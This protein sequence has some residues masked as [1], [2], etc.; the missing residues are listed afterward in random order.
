[1][2]LIDADNRRWVVRSFRRTG[3]AGSLL[4]LFLPFGPPQSRVAQELQ[5]LEPISLE[6]V[7]RRAC[8]AMEADVD[9]YLNG[10]PR[11]K[12]FEPLLAQVRAARSVSEIYDLLQPDTF[13]P[14]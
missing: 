14:N 3:R 11:E 7:R 5:P 13:E 4:S 6:D 10:D 8:D 1:M 2:E 9:S 12:E